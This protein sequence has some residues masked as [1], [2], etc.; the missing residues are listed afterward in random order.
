MPGIGLECG[1]D[2]FTLPCN[3]RS[4]TP[5]SILAAEENGGVLTSPCNQTNG[6]RGLSTP[7]LYVGC[8]I[9][10][11]PDHGGFAAG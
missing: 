7:S 8:D 3:C 1:S 2:N 10:A 9:S 11:R 6:L 5:A 4:K